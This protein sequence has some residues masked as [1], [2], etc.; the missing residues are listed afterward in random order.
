ME[1]IVQRREVRARDCSVAIWG[2]GGG[3]SMPWTWERCTICG[4]NKD[5]SECRL[6]EVDVVQRVAAK[7]RENQEP[8]EQY[9]KSIRFARKL[10]KELIRRERLIEEEEP[11]GRQLTGFVLIMVFGAMSMI[12]TGI[13]L[14]IH[15]LAGG[16]R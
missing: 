7:L 3:T 15:A 2:E 10:V 13:D 11:T 5:S 14:L 8:G 16:W 9:R 1:E 12:Y 4:A 6:T